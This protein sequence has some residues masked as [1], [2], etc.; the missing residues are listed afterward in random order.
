MLIPSFSTSLRL[1]LIEDK[2]LIILELNL[3]FILL[4]L[5]FLHY[6]SISIRLS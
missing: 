1:D 4:E 3:P 6:T 5:H 2:I